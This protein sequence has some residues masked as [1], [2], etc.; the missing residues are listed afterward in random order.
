MKLSEFRKGAAALILSAIIWGAATPILKKSLDTVPPFS[1][2]YLRF[3][4]AFILILPFTS[5]R[6]I[7]VERKHI[8]QIIKAS[9]FGIT[10]N[11]GLLFLGAKLTTGL[12][13]SVIIALDPLFTVIGAYLIL[14]EKLCRHTIVGILIGFLGTL[15][16]IGEPLLQISNFKTE[17]LIGDILVVLS[18]IAWVAYTIENKQ[19]DKLKSYHPLE[20]LPISFLIGVISFSP[21][22]IWEYLQNPLWVS[23]MSD[24]SKFGI[25]YYGIFSSF[26]A[27]IAFT[28][29]L[30]K[31]SATTAGL[32]C[33]IIPLISVLLSIPL[34]GEP[35]TSSFLFGATLI[36]IGLIL[37]ELR[38]SP[39]L[40]KMLHK[41]LS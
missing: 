21:L 26:L 16:I 11:I 14:K 9:I 33:Y 7:V 2:A 39:I 29:G 17:H 36:A 38:L 13:T 25:L 30:S 41:P 8:P 22:A 10:L 6:G 34:L 5:A 18:T 20:I 31:S 27:Y 37:T 1:M 28:W 4:I 23:N 24:F 40:H 19:L 35:I 12:H 3:V 32:V 15:V